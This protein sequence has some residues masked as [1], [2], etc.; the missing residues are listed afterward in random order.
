[1]NL[2]LGTRDDKVEGHMHRFNSGESPKVCGVREECG[3]VVFV[4]EGPATHGSRY[5]LPFGTLSE[6]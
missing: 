1:M 4:R 5:N 6:F 3:I 2:K